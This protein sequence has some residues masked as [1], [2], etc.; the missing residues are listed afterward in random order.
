[1]MDDCSMTSAEV[2]EKLLGALGL[3][4]VG[5]IGEVSPYAREKLE[6]SP[7][8]WYLTGFLVPRDRRVVRDLGVSPL[9]QQSLKLQADLEEE[10]EQENDLDDTAAERPTG[11]DD[12]DKETPKASG[13]PRFLPSS[14]GL[15][16]LAPG[17]CHSLRVI[18]RWGDYAPVEADETDDDDQGD[19]LGDDSPDYDPSIGGELQEMLEGIGEED[20]KKKH[21]RGP[22][23]WERTP[24]WSELTIELD[25]Q[26]DQLSEADLPGSNGLKLAWICRHTPREALDPAL[27]LDGAITVSIYLVNDRQ[28][29]VGPGKDLTYAFQAELEIQCVPGFVPRPGLSGLKSSDEDLRIADLQYRDVFD[30]AVGHNVSAAPDAFGEKCHVVRSAWI[31]TA[32]VELVQPAQIAGVELKMEALGLLADHAAALR[33]LEPLAKEYDQWILGQRATEFSFPERRDISAKLLDRA[34]TV[35]LRIHEG[36]QLLA[37]EKVFT[38]F[39]IANRAMAMQARQRMAQSKEI[40]PEDASEP[41]WRPFQLAFLLMNLKGVVDPKSED[42]ENVELLFFPTGGGKTEAYLGLAAFS[43]VFRRL[44]EGVSGVVPKYAGVT[45]LMRYTLRLLT[46]DQMGRAASLICAL[47]LIRREDLTKLGKW[48]FEIGLWVGAASTPNHM[49]HRRDEK[50]MVYRVTAYKNGTDSR[51]PIPMEKCPWCGRKFEKESYELYPGIDDATDLHI[52]CLNENCAF[53]GDN[54]LPV[55]MVDEPIYRRLPGFLIATVDKFASMPWRGDIASLFGKVTAYERDQG[56]VGLDGETRAR[57]TIA[58]PQNLPPPELIIQDELHL[59]SGP[60]GTIAGLFETAIEALSCRD[61]IV[62]KIVSSTATV[63]RAKEQIGALFGRSGVTIF[64]P[65]G[66]DRNDSFFARTLQGRETSR[67]YV[68]VAAQGRSVKRVV[69]RTY[70][71]LMSAVYKIYQDCGGAG[72]KQN[73][74]DPYM[75]LLGYFNSLREL[76][77][78]RRLVEDELTSR[79]KQYD[80]RKRV[81]DD[82]SPFVSREIKFE[83]QELTSRIPMD[84]VSA[85]KDALSLPHMDDARSVDISLATNMISV[86]LD[87]S[88]LGLMAVYAQPKMT[89][90]Y[91]QATSRVG[92]DKSKP[93]LVGTIFNISRARDR[94]HYERFRFYHDT[95]Y[96]GVEATSVTPFSPRALDRALF[97]VVVALARL[98]FDFMNGDNDAVKIINY[99]DRLDEIVEKIE[100]R[101]RKVAE[102]NAD[103]MSEEDIQRV[104]TAASSLLDHWLAYAR[105][106]KAD[107]ISLTYQDGEGKLKRKLIHDVLDPKLQYLPKAEYRKFVAGRSMRDVE[108]TVALLPKYFDNNSQFVQVSGTKSTISYIRQSQLVTTYGPGAMIDLPWFATVV[109]GLDFWKKGDQIAEPRL[110]Q[111]IQQSGFQVNGLYTPKPFVEPEDKKPPEG[112][113]V[114]R[115]PGWSLTQKTRQLID[116]ATSRTYQARLLVPPG[117]IDRSN[118][119]AD[120]PDWD[121][122][123]DNK[124]YD[125]VPIR[126]I[127]ACEAGHMDDIDWRA[128][129]H[130]DDATCQG[131]LWLD[132]MGTSGE[133][134]EL[135]VRCDGCGQS[136][137]LS[138]AAGKHNPSLGK[139]SGRQEWLGQE[140]RRVQCDKNMRLLIRT[141]SNAYF[142][143]KVS[144]ISLPDRDE[145]LRK[146][147]QECWQNCLENVTELSDISVALRFNPTAS[148]KLSIYRTEDIW[149]EI[150]A[151][152]NP[153]VNATQAADNIRTPELKLLISPE[154][155]LGED[156]L[157][158]PFFAEAVDQPVPTESSSMD[159]VERVVMI[160]RLREVTALTGYS[161]FEYVTQDV[162]DEI[163]FAAE[164]APLGKNTDWLPA[165]ENRGEGLFIQLKK[166]AVE[167]WAKLPEVRD[168]VDSFHR[169][170]ELYNEENQSK[171][172]FKGPEYVLLHTLSHLLMHTIALECGYPAASIKERIYNDSDIGYGIMLYTASSDSHGTLGGLASTARSIDLYLAKALE[173]GARCSNDPICGLHQPDDPHDKR[174]FHGAACHGCV[175]LS[176]TSCESM[177]DFLDRNLVVRTIASNR[178]HF[179]EKR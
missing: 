164:M 20:Q 163:P 170:V 118:G 137:G 146:A 174:H 156:G 100:C 154:K 93:G 68:G 153:Q 126:F 45:V 31:P 3:D 41:E 44:R 64:P 43:L 38:A 90:E 1:M 111:K 65:P 95:F 110:M 138:Q 81:D 132:E 91:I 125:I 98:S 155:F 158:S 35:A 124:K 17:N 115:F 12:T 165:V 99:R 39:R 23:I 87:I 148:A 19:H 131:N 120:L 149:A 27:A 173:L 102:L 139:C 13:K 32:T 18:A 76:G 74:A 57:G 130:G 62:P 136:R 54:H 107:H 48:P 8:Q 179:F 42:R 85:A 96:T 6:Q 36:V 129:V 78:T 114:W 28:G 117:W 161:R 2:R 59:I 168:A 150:Q 40:R 86:G 171:R 33:A 47:E 152:R 176:E 166:T 134:T 172:E 4:L 128:F 159:L 133:L 50:S 147:M 55:L 162:D 60:L 9:Q 177:N 25:N 26:K 22:T 104:K 29:I 72:N 16:V 101:V 15:T 94:S 121:R 70:L 119:K 24:G 63:R 178:R 112:V 122:K 61:G 56:F 169:G 151:R 83:V 105:E 143:I 135:R 157:D 108:H 103:S 127:R 51:R 144:V 88:R 92:R 73:P 30:F 84:K 109:S 7:S 142:P 5:P 141:A 71:A 10:D 66:P 49:G 106:L 160:H 21:K 140:Y 123:G 145:Q 69:L 79:L 75:T 80:G 116:A 53:S 113:V 175:Y 14:L 167:A 37:D 97:P 34:A 58:M 82:Q 89:S 77:G 67:L 46:L 11:A 52:H